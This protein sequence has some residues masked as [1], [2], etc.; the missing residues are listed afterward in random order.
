MTQGLIVITADADARHEAA[1]V[2]ILG[3][4]RLAGPGGKEEVLVRRVTPVQEIYLPG[5]GRGRFDVNLHSVAVTNAS[6]IL[7]VNV[8]PAAVTLKPGDEVKLDVSIERRADFDK[9]VT[10]DVVLGHLG[11]VH[12]NPLPPGVTLVPGKSK[13]LL[14]GG[15]KGHVTLKAAAN[16]A[17]IENVPISVVANVAINFVVKVAYS[18]P[19][20]PVTVKK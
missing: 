16:A 3:T 20:I 15:S 12:G 4:A 2:A 18:S 19:P 11:T 1:N 10:L 14:G 17:P 8:S 9:N 5:G 7:K 6:D 13:T